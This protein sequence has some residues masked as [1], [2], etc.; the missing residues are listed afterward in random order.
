MFATTLGIMN[1]LHEVTPTITHFILLLL[2]E[3]IHA[4]RSDSR[5]EKKLNK[6]KL[7]TRTERLKILRRVQRKIQR[8]DT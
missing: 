1:R 2:L 8:L 6:N 3:C 4:V 7:Y 5:E